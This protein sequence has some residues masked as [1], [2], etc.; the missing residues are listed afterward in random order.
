MSKGGNYRV[1]SGSIFTAPEK[2]QKNLRLLR[3]NEKGFSFVTNCTIGAI[4]PLKFGQVKRE[5]PP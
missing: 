3:Q 2:T 5:L 1:Y 4:L